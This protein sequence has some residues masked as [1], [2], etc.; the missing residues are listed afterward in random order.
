MTRRRKRS[1][2]FS[3]IE[4]IIALAVVTIA[5]MSVMGL[6]MS[7]TS[8]KEATR[9]LSLAQEAAAGEI[10]RLKAYPG[11]G[12]FDDLATLNATSSAVS[13]LNAGTLTRQ[14]DTTNPNLYRVTLVVT[15][16]S[17]AIARSH[18]ETVILSR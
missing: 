10:E 8:L 12:R 2:G 13:G 16:V 11:A 7:S 14:V 3:L 1:P 6:L 4:V 9:E 5:L 18:T 17:N 15:W